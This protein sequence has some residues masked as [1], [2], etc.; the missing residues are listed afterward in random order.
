MTDGRRSSDTLFLVADN[1]F[2]IMREHCVSGRNWLQEVDEFVEKHLLG[3]EM[4]DSWGRVAPAYPPEEEPVTPT[5]DDEAG[6]SSAR[7]EPIAHPEGIEIPEDVK[8]E[9]DSPP[10]RPREQREK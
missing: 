10:R 9:P 3:D 8:E 6:G 2:R 5:T 1:R 7:V 4:V